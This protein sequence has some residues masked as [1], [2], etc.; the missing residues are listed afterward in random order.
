[1]FVRWAQAP[2]LVTSFY[3]MLTAALILL[4]VK[5]LRSWGKSGSRQDPTQPSLS[6]IVF[7]AA[8]GLFTAL[9][10][11]TWS[12]AIATTQV[13]NATLLNNIAPLWVALYAVLVWGERLRGRFWLGLVITLAGAVLVLSSGILL[14]PQQTGGN[15]LALFS[16]MFYAAYFLVT[17]RGRSRL[18][19]L[20]YVWLVT[21]F[22][23]VSL[24][25]ISLILR[26]PLAGFVPQTWLVFLA[27]GL[28]S[29]IGG[30]FSIAYALG[31]LP[32]SVVS[33]T[34]ILQPVLT[35]LLAYVFAG[36]MLAPLQ[37]VGGLAAVGGIFLINISRGETL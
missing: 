10:H 4:P 26:L 12:T 11:S 24:L 16:S 14:S 7:P 8:G 36:E 29:Q 22:A 18:D 23:A 6:W 21:I 20:T 28:V 1:M 9:D 30:Y 31:H 37:W 35:A 33:P 32:A 13:A 5:I 3:R 15:L 25:A 34:M 2:G 17:Q 19:A 27:A